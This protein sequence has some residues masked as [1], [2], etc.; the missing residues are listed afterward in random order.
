[1][2][3][4]PLPPSQLLS[5]SLGSRHFCALA[6][7]CGFC[8]FWWSCWECLHFIIWTNFNLLFSALSLLV[9]RNFFFFLLWRSCFCRDIF[10]VYFFHWQRWV[11][12]LIWGNYNLWGLCFFLSFCARALSISL[13][14]FLSKTSCEVSCTTVFIWINLWSWH[15]M[16]C[17]VVH[18][19]GD[20]L[21]SELVYW[22]VDLLHIA[23]VLCS[24]W[25]KIQEAWKFM[26]P[27][28]GFCFF[29]CENHNIL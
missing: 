19:Q 3:I 16:C 1:M 24:F 17:C 18:V 4:G 13:V 5:S 14:Y 2:S 23:Q 29:T 25:Q 27:A 28:L 10:V 15:I 21:K 20:S 12:K 22:S 11:H 8:Q 7:Y 6:V 26:G 9:P